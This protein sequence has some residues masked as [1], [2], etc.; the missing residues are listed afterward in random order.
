MVVFRNPQNWIQPTRT[1]HSMIF[2]KFWGNLNMSAMPPQPIWQKKTQAPG[3]RLGAKGIWHLGSF[4]TDLHLNN[5]FEDAT[6]GIISMRTRIWPHMILI[7]NE[8]QPS[9]TNRAAKVDPRSSSRPRIRFKGQL[10]KLNKSSFG[11]GFDS[12]HLE[13]QAT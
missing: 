1:H 11:S 8:R 12:E 6:L 4:G 9:R 10:D 3:L 13:N 5:Q 2:N 7:L